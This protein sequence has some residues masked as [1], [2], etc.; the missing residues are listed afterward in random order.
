MAA[1]QGTSPLS[2]NT[3]I[4]VETLQVFIDSLKHERS[5]AME[6]EVFIAG[7]LIV[8]LYEL[9]YVGTKCEYTDWNFSCHSSLALHISSSDLF[10]L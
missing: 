2:T 6:Q 7:S 3:A 5:K 9:D 10:R 1:D 8:V 4:W